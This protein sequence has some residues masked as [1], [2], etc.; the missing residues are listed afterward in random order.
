MDSNTVGR[1]HAKGALRRCAKGR[2]SGIIGLDMPRRHR[3]VSALFLIV[4]LLLVGCGGSVEVSE[5][6][7]STLDAL[8]NQNVAA[9]PDAMR[10]AGRWQANKLIGGVDYRVFE[11]TVDGDR[12]HLY[13]ES[14]DDRGGLSLYMYDVEPFQLC[15]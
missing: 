13:Y 12:V 8:L 3:L 5:D 2:S 14:V 1:Y 15:E 9:I 7:N 11:T 6:N 4:A 10:S